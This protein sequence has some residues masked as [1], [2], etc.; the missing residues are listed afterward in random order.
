MDRLVSIHDSV[1]DVQTTLTIAIVLVVLVI[2]LFLRS[3]SA[4]IIPSLAVSVSLI[5]TCGAMYMLGYSINNMTMLDLVDLAERDPLRGRGRGV[6][7]DRARDQ[8]QLE[9]AFPKGTHGV[10]PCQG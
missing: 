8:R 4:T 6:K 3:V 2:F 5:A 1:K 9:I 7:T 10:T